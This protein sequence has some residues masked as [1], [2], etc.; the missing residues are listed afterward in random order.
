MLSKYGDSA[1]ILFRIGL[2]SNKVC[3]YTE[4]PKY[5]PNFDGMITKAKTWQEAVRGADL[6]IFDDNA[7]P[8]VWKQ[9][10][11]T[12]PCFGGS[13]FGARLENDRAYAH[14]IMNMAGLPRIESKT[15]RTL[16]DVLPHLKEH[17]VPHVIK[18]QGKKVES[19]HIVVGDGAN[20]DDAIDEVQRLIEQGLEVEA[21]EVE[22]RKFGLET[23][24]GIWCDGKG[25]VGP[26]E[27]NFERKHSHDRDSGFL[28][29]E[30]GTILKYIEDPELPLFKDTIAKLL[31]ILRSM[32]YRGE[33]DLNMIVD[34]LGQ[35][36]PLE[37][38][39]R[40]GKPSVFIQDE[41]N[42]TSWG[43]LFWRCATGQGNPQFRY[44][45]AVGVCKVSFGFPSETEHM[46]IS[47]SLS[48]RGVNEHNL[49]HIHPWQMRLSKGQFVVGPGNGYILT[50]TGRGETIETAGQRA[51]S[52]LSEVGV[53]GSWQRWD[54]AEKRDITSWGLERLGILPQE[55]TV[56]S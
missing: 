39:P 47:N 45:W 13:D 50:A 21:V 11:K 28:T 46:K 9:I 3:M 40:L 38:T 32:N 52:A 43:D 23:G 53:K 19:H 15:Y 31:P 6:V 34:E 5:A 12:I 49:D 10:H 30:M 20:N 44:D 17:K 2:D 42:V 18:P 22:E 24:L 56:P 25:Q 36:W 37:F 33:L 35:A 51:Y 26:V 54:I 16:K 48:V 27:L 55:E 41:L 14:S 8:E 4:D 1:D 7:M 29:S